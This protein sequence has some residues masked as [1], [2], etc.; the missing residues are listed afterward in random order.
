MFL[1]HFLWLGRISAP[2][3]IFCA[4]Q[5]MK[6]THSKTRYL[7]RLY[8]FGILIAIFQAYSQSEL[9]FIRTLFSICLLIY[10]FELRKRNIKNYKW[11]I[12]A[13]IIYQILVCIINAIIIFQSNSYSEEFF[14]YLLPALMGS[15]FA[16]DGGLVYVT[17]GLIIYFFQDSKIILS[18]SYSL[19]VS[20]Y[21]FLMA[22]PIIPVVLGKIGTLNFLGEIISDFLLYLLEVI[23][24][25][26]P[27]QMNPNLL[28]GSYQWMMIFALPFMLLYNGKKGHSMKWFFYIFYP[29]HIILFWFI[30]HCY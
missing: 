28:H 27:M 2:L 12:C 1:W 14:I 29:V 20:I 25:I 22:Y 3:F 7:L 5:G 11:I 9:N 30:S 18:V 16:L 24:G 19:G 23:I 10:I 4:V 13:Y 26:Q 21:T 15:I 8:I 6:H 17:A